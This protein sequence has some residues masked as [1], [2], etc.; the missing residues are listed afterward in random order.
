MNIGQ[1]KQYINDNQLPDDMN[2]GLMDLT[3]DDFNDRNY[4][5]EEKDLMVDDCCEEDCGEVTGK[6][7]FITFENVLN[8]NPI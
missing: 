5:L 2:I 1:L 8:D 4:G 7:L 6:M 3:T